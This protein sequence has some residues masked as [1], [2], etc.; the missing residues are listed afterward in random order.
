MSSYTRH[1]LD[2][3][4]IGENNIIKVGCSFRFYEITEIR[5]LDEEGIVEIYS[6][7]KLIAFIPARHITIYYPSMEE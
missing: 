3:I 1:K 2:G 5:F 4:Q 7:E 6:E